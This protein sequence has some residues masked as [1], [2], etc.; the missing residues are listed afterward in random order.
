MDKTLKKEIKKFAKEGEAKLIGSLFR[1]RYRKDKRSAP[2]NQEIEERSR[3]FVDQAHQ[4][5]SK[6]GKN[7]WGELKKGVQELKKE[8]EPED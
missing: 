2:T 3:V 6:R 7:I 1:W 8:E 4:I 5:L